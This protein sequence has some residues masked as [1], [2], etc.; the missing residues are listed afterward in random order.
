MALIEPLRLGTVP[1]GLRHLQRVDDL[2]IAGDQV[3][4]A[5]GVIIVRRDDD[6]I[7]RLGDRR[8]ADALG[9][10]GIGDHR[11]AR[12]VGQLERRMT[13]PGD[14]HSRALH[15]HPVGKSCG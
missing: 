7:R 5:M 11:P 4:A 14:L 12:R 15:A 13:E 1:P 8:I 10:V 2:R 3:G 9:R 6:E